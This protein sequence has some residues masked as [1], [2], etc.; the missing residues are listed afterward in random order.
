M[1][2]IVRTMGELGCEVCQGDPLFVLFIESLL[3]YLRGQTAHLEIFLPGAKTSHHAI[4]FA[5]DCTG[6]LSNIRHTREFVETVQGYDTN[7]G[8]T[9]NSNK[10]IVL[11]FNE[12]HPAF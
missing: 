9:L 12:V 11:H 8:L 10:T 2:V 6:I 5:D 4:A 1:R 7:A 3:C